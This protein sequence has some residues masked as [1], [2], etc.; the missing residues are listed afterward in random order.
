MSIDLLFNPSSVAVVG[1][2]TESGTVGQDIY[3]NLLQSYKGKVYP[4]NPK[5]E[6]LLGNICYKDVSS[7]PEVPEMVVIAVPAKVVM[8]V[9][10]ECGKIGVKAV[11]VI[12]AGFKEVSEEGFLLE[13]QIKE[14]C[15][16]HGIRLL[17]VNCLG[18][19]NVKTEMNATFAPSMPRPGN[20]SFISQSGALCTAVIDSA[21]EYGL[22]FAKILSTGN[23]TDLDEIDILEYLDT[24]PDTSVIMMYVESIDTPNFL[25]RAKKIKKPIIVLKTGRSQ[26]GQIAASSHTGALGGSDQVYDALFR[27][28]GI[29]RAY[30]IQDLFNYTQAFSRNT[31][32]A[33]NRVAILTNAGGPGGLTVDAVEMGGLHLTKLTPNTVEALE[34][35]LPEAANTQNPV[36]ILGDARSDRYT[37][38]LEILLQDSNV[39]SIIVILTPQSVTE[40]EQTAKA[41]ANNKIIY[42]KPIIA[43]FMGNKAVEQGRNFLFDRSVA[44]VSFPDQAAHALGMLYFRKRYLQSQSRLKV[45][46]LSVLPEI[47]NNIQNILTM[48][49]NEG[50]TLLHGDFADQILSSYNLETLKR[51]VVRSRQEALEKGALVGQNLALKIISPDVVHK[52]DVGGVMLGVK[53]QDA[54]DAFDKI[55][56]SV[57]NNLPNARI[58]GVLIMEMANLSE[59][60]ELIIGSKDEGNIG[61]SIMVGLG[62]VLVEA[63]KDVTFSIGK[64]N[65]HEAMQMIQRL[66]SKALFYGI[67]GFPIMDTEA[68]AD[69]LIKVSNLVNDFKE[70]SELDIN[71][72]LIL[73]EGKGCKILDSRIILK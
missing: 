50:R 18:V 46:T 53:A 12:T 23:K 33:G 16:Q 52:S 65:H 1:A 61:K 56:L 67:R 69:S 55:I 63:L 29:I 5:T 25:E 36:D 39:D 15:N 24:D 11:V 32:P 64:I 10:Q 71:P 34:S 20:I 6:I 48:S 58:D 59:G 49:K 72:I 44:Q 54:G 66:K 62:G 8:K 37:K 9:L 42:G 17:G 22:G 3:K 35:F 19:M 2:S 47:K 28:A 31:L 13:K 43:S 57:K 21:S 14:L 40:V 73:P 27:Q 68:L 4:I 51:A 70:I 41:I 7:L 38:S 60:F 30:T 26:A 45:T